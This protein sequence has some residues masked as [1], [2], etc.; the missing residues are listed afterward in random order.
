MVD[1]PRSEGR[2]G[3]PPIPDPTVLTTEALH[4]EVEQLQELLE[5]EIG[6]LETLCEEREKRIH[7]HFDL[8]ERSRVEQKED[9]LK[10]VAAALSSQK[11]AVSKSEVSVTKQLD[12]LSVTIATI[13]SSLRRSIDDLKERIVMTEGSIN[14]IASRHAGAKDSQAGLYA[15]IGG[16]AA[17]VGAVVVVANLLTG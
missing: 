15:A 8:L 14:T 9:T 7:Q 16:G 11:E 5:L 10:A 2:N 12:Q 1:E 17:L 6:S 4:R 13:E 3:R